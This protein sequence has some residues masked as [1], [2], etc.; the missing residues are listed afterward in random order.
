VY[1]PLVEMPSE[2]EP[3]DTAEPG[4]RGTETVL[5]C[6]DEEH[7]R[8]LLETMLARQ[9]YCVLPAEGPDQALEVARKHSAEIDLLLTDIVMP[10][11]S[12]FDLAREIRAIRPDIKL[13]LMSGYTDNRVSNSWVLDPATPFLQKPF[14]AVG[15]AQKVREALE[16]HAS[17]K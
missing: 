13:L 3:A 11:K 10:R 16:S 4:Q 6:E 12:G 15:L 9:G 7:I 17:A 2:L 8:K 14:T 5:L 1:L